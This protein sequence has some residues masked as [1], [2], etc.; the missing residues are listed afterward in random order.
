MVSI[1]ENISPDGGDLLQAA[2]LAYS[3]G[4]FNQ[5]VELTRELINREPECAQAHFYLGLSLERIGHADEGNRHLQQAFHLEPD[6]AAYV[7]ALA[8]SHYRAGH[9]KQAGDLFARAVAIDPVNIRY[10][11]SWAISLMDSGR[12]DEALRAARR[13]VRQDINNA[14]LHNTLGLIYTHMNRPKQANKAFRFALSM[15]PGSVIAAMNLIKYLL[16]SGSYK[17]ALQTIEH[18]PEK[19]KSCPDIEWLKISA[20]MGA[21]RL[22]AAE[23]ALREDYAKGNHPVRSGNKLIKLYLQ[24]GRYE[25]AYDI[26]QDLHDPERVSDWM[27]LAN[28][29]ARWL[30]GE[31][32]ENAARHAV[33]LKPGSATANRLL[34]T[35][36]NTRGDTAGARTSFKRALNNDNNDMASLRGLAELVDSNEEAEGMLEILDREN[37]RDKDSERIE[38]DF[39]RGYLMDRLGRYDEAFR[40]Y[41]NANSLKYRQSPWNRRASWNF[42]MVNHNYF[43]P[44]VFDKFRDLGSDSQR[45]ILIVG[46]P[47]SGSTLCERILA[48]HSTVRD[49][50]E[51][52][53]LHAS[54]RWWRYQKNTEEPYPKCLE[55]MSRDDLAMLA[56]NYIERLAHGS[57][58]QRLTH[59]LLSNFNLLGLVAIMLPEARIIHCMRDPLD[60]CL[61]CY[62][63]HFTEGNEFSSDLDALGEYYQFY[64]AMMELWKK[65][66]PVPVYDLHYEKLVNEPEA[67][68]RKLFDYL[69]LEWE[70]A[71][72]DFSGRESMVVTSSVHQVRRNIYTSS[73]NRW[74][75]YRNHLEPLIASLGDLV[76]VE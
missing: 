42:Y 64:S 65:V 1:R 32:A 46:M 7:N 72:L 45:P 47:R 57:D 49:C 63:Q 19:L 43:S 59:K 75:N 30:D 40:A 36:L 50:G 33:E 67:E 70:D 62:F 8:E 15:D 13:A 61:S 34:A 23:K 55:S 16:N 48:S 37:G 17:E 26:M 52:N 74:K 39:G 51:R 60:T 28:L 29:H 76:D 71:C 5:C 66:L 22:N 20:L 31:A 35:I 27:D 53:A 69:D 25:E 9:I 14:E 56:G 10:L 3:Q 44:G 21:G 24:Q 12:Y 54:L 6:E 38:L 73:Q 11:N 18:F 2:T 58:K 41:A 4:S 68:C